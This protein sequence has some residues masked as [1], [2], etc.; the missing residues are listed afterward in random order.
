MIAK[1]GIL[2]IVLIN[3]VCS[4]R[5]LYHEL[6][7]SYGLKGKFFGDDSETMQVASADASSVETQGGDEEEAE[8]DLM[9]KLIRRLAKGLTTKL[10]DI[11]ELRR[12]LE[13]L[14]EAVQR[15]PDTCCK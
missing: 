10:K 1:K 14:L 15:L 13:E 7:R 9:Q 6:Q 11:T 12:S 8:N 4:H 5:G 3:R 2:I